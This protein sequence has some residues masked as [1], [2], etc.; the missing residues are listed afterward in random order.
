MADAFQDIL[1]PPTAHR[2]LLYAFSAL[3][4][5]IVFALYFA[6]KPIASLKV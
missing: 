5:P 1:K 4:Y 2:Q 6:C 3:V